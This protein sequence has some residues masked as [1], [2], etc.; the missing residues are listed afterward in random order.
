MPYI[1]LALLG[2]V[3]LFGAEPYYRWQF[4]NELRRLR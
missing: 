3:V 2:L 1:I 4:K